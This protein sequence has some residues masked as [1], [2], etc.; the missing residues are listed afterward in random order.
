M[1]KVRRAVI[2]EWMLLAREKRQSSEQA[3]AFARAALQRH[4]LPR[5][6]RRTPYEIIMRWLRPR[7]GRP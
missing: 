2:R 1:S 7:T 5:S 3:A 4:D 6:S